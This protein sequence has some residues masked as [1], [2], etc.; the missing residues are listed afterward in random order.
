VLAPNLPNPP[1]VPPLGFNPPFTLALTT[2]SFA[3]NRGNTTLAFDERGVS[4]P[5]GLA[6]DI[7]AFELQVPNPT[8]T[9]TVT[10][11]T[12]IV[13]VS[14]SPTIIPTTVIQ[15]VTATPSI[16][17][18]IKVVVKGPF[19][20][21]RD[22]DRDIDIDRDKDHRERRLAK[23]GENIVG[24]AVWGLWMIAGG[25]VALRAGRRPRWIY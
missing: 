14:V 21:D 22:R 23:T 5:Q 19:D 16:L 18:V 20:K 11:P 3:F 9:P 4:R 24:Y 8:P 25:V 6:A 17:G 1:V 7:G 12:P 10:T 15:T 2:S 13:T